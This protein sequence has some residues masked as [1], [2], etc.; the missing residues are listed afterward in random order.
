MV[1]ARMR[2][3]RRGSNAQAEACALRLRSYR[4]PRPEPRAPSPESRIPSPG[5][6]ARLLRPHDL[7]RSLRALFDGSEITLHGR[8]AGDERVRLPGCAL[9]ER[10]NPRVGSVHRGMVREH[11]VGVRLLDHRTITHRLLGVGEETWT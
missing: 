7:E 8:V 3:A 9:R 4:P 5:S 6:T 1:V 10:R 11:H 2:G